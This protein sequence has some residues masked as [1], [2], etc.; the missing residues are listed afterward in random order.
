MSNHAGPAPMTASESDPLLPSKR[1]K[2]FYRP[3]P[4]WLVPFA[5]TGA[6]VRGMTLAPRVEVFTQLSCATVHKHHPYNHTNAIL[7]P[8]NPEYMSIYSALDPV[9]PHLSSVHSTSVLLPSHQDDDDGAQEEDP[10]RLPSERCISD[11]KVTAGAA[12]LQ[13][14]MTTTMGF[15]SALTTGWWGHFSERHGRTRVL[16][17]STLGLFLTDLTFILV[18]TPGSA[19]SSHGHKLLILAPFIEGCLGGWSTLQSATSSY[20]SDCTSAGSRAKI[21][22]RFT[23][24]FYLGFA[25][26]PTIG[27]WIIR[28]GIPGIDRIGTLHGQGKSV[29]EVFWLA[30]CCS[31]INLFL[32]A[33][34]FPESLSKEQ[35]ARA[36]EQYHANSK[37]KGHASNQDS[38]GSVSPAPAEAPPKPGAIRRFLSPLAVF[39][40]AAISRP[41]ASGVVK[42]RDWS[43]TFLALSVLLFMLSTGIYQIKYIYAEHVYGWG[44]DKLSYYISFAGGLRAVCLLFVMPAVISTFKPTVQK[45]TNKTASPTKAQ[46]AQ[47]IHFD[48]MLTR[49]CICIDICSQFLVS[50]SPSPSNIH[51]E[52]IRSFLTSTPSQTSADRRSEIFFVLAS[53]LSGFGAGFLPAAQS[54]ALCIVQARQLLESTASERDA[55]AVA[56]DA[57]EESIKPKGDSGIGKLFGALSVLQAVGQMIMGPLLFGLV[58]SDSVAQFPKA[59]FVTACGILVGALG[60][61][62]LI[63]SP[64]QRERPRGKGKAPMKGG[65][66]RTKSSRLS[67]AEEEERRGRSRASKDLFGYGV[68]I[69]RDNEE[70]VQRSTQEAGPSL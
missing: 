52:S 38:D 33:F 40:P 65:A 23:G 48:L 63:R 53:S 34:V 59:I 49:I 5:I 67:R 12:R 17:I 29:T 1:K 61:A 22:S 14:I 2:P 45:S 60:F 42:T 30:I 16:A 25:L 50:I 8:H 41:T 27:G 44:A 46:L 19:L 11:P 24:V 43:L 36:I 51:A 31:F 54:L 39:F 18:A 28:N 58:Y 9:G 13:T 21:F 4:L 26:G 10:R 7:I 32:V 6:L 3:R 15:L 64:V 57:R 70:Q 37:G 69:T 35:R 55:S 62:S 47:E 56:S 68:P 66:H 20:V